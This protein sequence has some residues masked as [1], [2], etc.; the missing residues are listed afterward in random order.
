MP[1][2]H[3][4]RDVAAAAVAAVYPWSGPAEERLVPCQW[5]GSGFAAV[6][7]AAAAAGQGLDAG[8]NAGALGWLLKPYREA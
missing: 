8:V 4:A 3:P 1:S 7:A 2:V 6:A 5:A